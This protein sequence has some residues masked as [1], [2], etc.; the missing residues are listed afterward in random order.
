MA[1]DYL[2]KNPQLR[3]SLGKKGLA[4][5]RTRYHWEFEENKLLLLYKSLVSSQ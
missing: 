2:Y 1:I 3:E 5:V 4:A